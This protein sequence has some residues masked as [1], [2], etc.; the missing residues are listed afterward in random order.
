MKGIIMVNKQIRE[1]GGIAVRKR[2]NKKIQN[3]KDRG[4]EGKEFRNRSYQIKMIEEQR[5]RSQ[6]Y[7]KSTPENKELIRDMAKKSGAIDRFKKIQQR[8]QLYMLIETKQQLVRIANRVN[9]FEL[10]FENLKNFE[11][12]RVFPCELIEGNRAWISKSEETGKHRYFTMHPGEKPYSLSIFDLI[13]IVDGVRGFQYATEEL[14]RLLDLNNLQDEW[15]MVQREKYQANIDYLNGNEVKIKKKYPTLYRYVQKQMEILK[16]LNDYGK[17]HTNRMFTHRDKHIFYVSTTELAK[18]ETLG[19]DQ[20]AV[21]R[22]VNLLALLGL[23]KKIPFDDLTADIQAV[24]KGIRGNNKGFRY[25]TFYQIPPLN[26]D[27]LLQ[28]EKMAK[29]LETVGICD[30]RDVSKK[31]IGKFLGGV[32]FKSIYFRFPEGYEPN[33]N[34]GHPEDDE[35][36]FE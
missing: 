23:I 7:I 16:V 31:N 21:N 18:Q 36:P 35:L 13:E 30:G 14:A 5:A 11:I 22:A 8:S 20:P 3:L 25:V 29:K 4:L 26:A 10:I 1:N 32:M 12:D 9:M 6:R 17:K 27:V 24:A 34:Q 33:D 2:I 28:A 15:E 19:L